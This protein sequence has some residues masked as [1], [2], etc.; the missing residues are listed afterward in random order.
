MRPLVKGVAMK[1]RKPFREI[2]TS[3]EPVRK[4]S[5]VSYLSLQGFEPGMQYD[6]GECF[7]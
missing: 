6:A 4:S 3:N 1:I 5:Y 2:E 7:L